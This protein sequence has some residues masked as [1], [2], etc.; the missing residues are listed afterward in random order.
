MYQ[1]PWLIPNNIY[2]KS[3]DVFLQALTNPTLRASK[4]KRQYPVEYAG[5]NFADADSAFFGLREMLPETSNLML[6]SDINAA[7][8]MQHPRLMDELYK[9][10]GQGE[11]SSYLNTLTH[12]TGKGSPKWEGDGLQSR[13]I[14]ALNTGFKQAAQ[15]GKLSMEDEIGDL[16]SSGYN[17][18]TSNS[19][20]RY[21]SQLR[22]PIDSM[23]RRM[24]IDLSQPQVAPNPQPSM[25]AMASDVL[26]PLGERLP[27][28]ISDDLGQ[29]YLAMQETMKARQALQSL[30]AFANQYD[31]PY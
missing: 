16:L 11:V 26:E 28:G 22:R 4:L 3:P 24:A 15:V 21:A 12:R 10:A 5:Y 23:G 25:S 1:K 6:L 19:L 13:A 2:S 7:K 27:R 18:L 20:I 8:F 30:A 29:Q 31:I 9:R 17:P 14:Q